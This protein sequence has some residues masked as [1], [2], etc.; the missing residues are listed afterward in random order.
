MKRTDFKSRRRGGAPQKNED[1]MDVRERVRRAFLQVIKNDA[2][3]L[4]V[5]ANERSIT[6]RLGI[7]LQEV[8][9]DYHVDCEY[10]RNGPEDKRLSKFEKPSSTNDRDGRTVFPD[11]IIHLRGTDQNMV[12]IEAKKSSNKQTCAGGDCTC[13]RCKLQTYQSELGYEFAFFVEF[14]VNDKLRCF[15]DA[16]VD[17][18]VELISRKP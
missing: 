13:D 4:T 8:F 3:L 6:H 17:D 1:L 18:F 9:P 14:P 16:K 10:N 11:I 5:D 15:A 2:H 7:Y 12:V